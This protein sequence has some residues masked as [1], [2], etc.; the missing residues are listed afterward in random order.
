M[1]TSTKNKNQVPASDRL[2]EKLSAASRRERVRT[3]TFGGLDMGKG[4]AWGITEMRNLSPRCAP[5]L[6]T[7][8]RRELLLSFPLVGKYHGMA[9]MSGCLYIACGS[10]LY[11]IPQV[12]SS[13]QQLRV[14]T[15][16]RLS[17]G[18]KCMTVFGDRLLILP[19]KVYVEEPGLE[20]LPMELDTGSM[21]GLTFYGDTI[22]LPPGK[23]WKTFGFFAGDSVYVSQTSGLVAEGYYRILKLSGSTATV[24]PA[25]SYSPYY[26]A[27]GYE[28]M[29]PEKIIAPA[30]LERHVPDLESMAVVGDRVF[31]F[32]N[33]SIYIG[34]QGSPFSWWQLQRD[35]Q[36]PVTLERCTSES[37]TACAARGDEMVFFTPSS[38]IRVTGG[39]SGNFTLSEI[40][41]AGIPRELSHTLCEME[42]NLYYHGTDGV[43]V[44]GNTAQTPK[45][46]GRV[47]DGAPTYGCAV[48]YEEGYYLALENKPLGQ[49]GVSGRYLYHPINKAWYEETDIRMIDGVRLGSYLCSLDEQGN[50]WLSRTDGRRLYPAADAEREEKESPM[51]SFVS[52]VPDYSHH[53]DG[54]RPTNLYLRATSDGSGELK[55]LMSFADGRCG[56][57]AHVPA[58]A[59]DGRDWENVREVACITG[60]MQD[61]LLRIPLPPRRCDYVALALEMQGDW[62]IHEITLEYETPRR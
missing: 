15:V 49:E 13:L 9:V 24:S 11:C 35:S 56:L 18:D 17:D 38:M 53:P 16:G 36:G 39:R 14:L 34:G 32:R 29:L 21:E 30:R 28:E 4:Q 47:F 40:G 43:Y 51:H 54:C 23:T 60:N 48:A 19:D 26:T 12:L 41:V 58:D 52:F 61:R 44:Y 50:L 37:F 27:G 46:L 57:D 8:P 1:L 7:R 2:P 45:S 3:T 31:G 42:G 22:S 20:L 5:S 33:K 10:Y 6:A 25:V 59:K 62:V 55:V